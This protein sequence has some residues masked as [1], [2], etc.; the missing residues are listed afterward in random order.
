[1][2]QQAADHSHPE[3]PR[4]ARL[5]AL[6]ERLANVGAL[7]ADDDETRLKKALTVLIALVILPVAFT[8]A[9]LY[10]AFGA[11]T[12][13]LAVNYAVISV[14]SILLFARTKNYELFLNIQLLDILLSPTVSMIP[15]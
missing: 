15:I 2:A 7:P 13:W 9:A 6:L 12:G 5:D 10:L 8:W 11:W 14:I 1:M 3:T 4:G